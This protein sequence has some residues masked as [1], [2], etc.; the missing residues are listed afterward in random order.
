MEKQNSFGT[1]LR[2]GGAKGNRYCRM[3]CLR[4]VMI[5]LSMLAIA[6][7]VGVVS[8]ANTACAASSGDAALVEAAKKEKSLSIIHG[9]PQ[10]NMQG[11]AK[12][13]NRLYPFI[14][15][16]IER[17]Q[18]LAVYEK[19]NT[20][21]RSGSN[22]RDI[23]MLADMAATRKLAENKMIL[24]YRVPTDADIPAAFKIDGYAYAAYLTTMVVIVNDKLVSQE[25][26]KILREWEGILDPRWK[27]R[28]G[29][30]YPAGG[31]VY[32]PLYMYLRPPTPGRFGEKFLRGLAA[33]QPQIYNST[34]TAIERVMAGE[35]H[36][37][38]THFE[39]DAIPRWEQGAP[40]R[41]YA[42][43]PTPS[44]ANA[45]FGIAAKAPNPNAAKL[46]MNWLLSEDGATAVNKI[47]ASISTLGTH[48]D[49]RDLPKAPWY[50]PVTE[51]F[52]PDA[53]GWLKYQDADVKLWREI[54]NY[55][56]G[57]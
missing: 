24:N 48:K 42:P 1:K 27:G 25:E 38:F 31:S 21:T 26:G 50:M 33:Q 51:T 15:V 45:Y 37:L 43:K 39:S 40:I 56:P 57:R 28:I 20:E 13:F 7:L 9:M 16:E 30:S 23:V 35:I 53:D 47:S 11:L 52:Q 54:F 41:W 10:A 6:I 8:E 2:I 49:Q 29:T 3:P 46:W 36:V 12:A 17:Q 18:G 34:A 22:L 55:K 19:F 32:G 5:G 14:S 4:A 44:F